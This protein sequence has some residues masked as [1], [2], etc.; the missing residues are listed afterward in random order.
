MWKLLAYEN[1]TPIQ[2]TANLYGS[3]YTTGRYVG[4][5][6]SPAH[7][8]VNGTD[9]DFRCCDRHKPDENSCITEMTELNGSVH[10]I[11]SNRDFEI[12]IKGL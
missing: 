4:R 11:I 6:C 5:Q 9:Y 2:K 12:N 10:E 1:I 3:L 7:A 8:E